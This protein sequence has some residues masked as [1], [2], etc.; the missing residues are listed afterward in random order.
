MSGNQASNAPTTANSNTLT[1]AYNL[2]GCTPQHSIDDIKSQFRRLAL[3]YHPDKG[4]DENVFN[5]IKE[6][7]KLVFRH[8]KAQTEDTQH[9]ELK[10]RAQSYMKKRANPSMQHGEAEPP[11]NG[12]HKGTTAPPPLSPKADGDFHNKFNQFFDEN[13]TVDNNTERGYEGFISTP[14]VKVSTNHYK[15]KKYE[16]PTGTV[17]CKSLGFHELGKK[18]SDFSGK[19]DDM[20]KLQFMDY[21]YAHTTDKIIDPSS[22]KQRKE[23]S[24]LDDI[25]ASRESENFSLTDRDRVVYEKTRDRDNRR[26]HRRKA[27]LQSFDHYLTEHQQRMSQMA[28]S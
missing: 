17:L 25:R 11:L 15:I 6:N 1:N 12:A 5:T 22:V 2:L 13:R 27:N 23:F 3:K 14:D 8:K 9:P 18:I 28:I 26:E 10:A 4:G 21:K 20:H 24:S 7:F 19:N 16:E